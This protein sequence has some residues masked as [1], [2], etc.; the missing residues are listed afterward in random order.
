MQ[1]VTTYPL[2]KVPQLTLIFWIIKI[3]ATTLGETGGDLVSMSLGYGY[4]MSTCIFAMVFFIAVLSQITYKEFHSLLYWITIIAT[5]TVGTTL[6]DFADRSL[7]MGYV[8]GSLG[9][10][11]SVGF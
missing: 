10:I 11:E 7:G 1:K 2:S 6:A 9:A 3:A 5:T 4:L 8:G